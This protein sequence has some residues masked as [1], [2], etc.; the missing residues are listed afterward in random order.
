MQALF[1]REGGARQPIFDDIFTK[2]TNFGV[3]IEEVQLTWDFV[4]ASHEALHGPLIDMRNKALAAVTAAGPRITFTEVV[5]NTLEEDEFIWLDIKGTFDVPNFM[6][7]V[8]LPGST[9]YVFNKDES[10]EIVQ[11]GWQRSE[12]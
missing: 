11:N 6:K 12:L 8:E 3:N 7:A 1:D 9:A 10:G 2:L 5:E 4:T